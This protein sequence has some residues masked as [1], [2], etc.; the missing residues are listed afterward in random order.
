MRG[1]EAQKQHERA[2]R[3]GEEEEGVTEHSF[4]RAE[5]TKALLCAVLRE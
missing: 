4:S 5:R 2:A 3:G 1:S